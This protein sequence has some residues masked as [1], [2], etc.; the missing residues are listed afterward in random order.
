MS[1]IESEGLRKSI[2]KRLLETDEVILR[3][4][5]GTIARAWYGEYCIVDL[6]TSR[7]VLCHVDLT[8][9]LISEIGELDRARECGRQRDRLTRMGIKA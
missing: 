8:D 9:W 5:E 6:I 3:S 1:N 4:P 7:V 2:N